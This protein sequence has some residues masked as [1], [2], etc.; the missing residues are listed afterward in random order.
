[1]A[2]RP[3]PVLKALEVNPLMKR[4]FW[5]LRR[6]STTIEPRYFV[7]LAE[8]ALAIVLIAAMLVTWFEAKAD[9]PTMELLGR[10]GR[11]ATW[12]FF[13]VLGQG[14]AGFVTTT[15]S[16]V[17]SWLLAL[18]GVAIVGTITGT[19]VALV[20][21]FLL[22][23]G[24][25]MGAAGYRDHIVVCGWNSTARDLIEELK[26]DEYRTKVVV[27]A[28]LEK[29]P[30][31][32]GVYFVRGDTTSAVDL[33][34][35]GIEDAAAALVFPSAPTNEADMQS[36]L[37]VMAIE[38]LAPTVRTVVEAV[39]PR[40]VEHF[41]RANADEVLVT[42]TLASRLLARSALY[43][44]LTGLVTD[45]V[46]GGAGSEL[47]RVEL[48][49][50]Y[51][52]LTIDEVSARLRAE[53]QATILAVSRGSTTFVNPKS[54]FRIEAGDDALVVALSLG[55]LAPL[56]ADRGMGG[57]G[58]ASAPAPAPGSAHAHAG[59]HGKRRAR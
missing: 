25:G 55:T 5:H 38:A 35:A 48:P 13:T 49:D 58:A 40:H 16:F 47:Y 11:T 22:K 44:G 12:S 39:N 1:M 23:E 21:D 33:G 14:S 29:N 51:L 2:G 6:T 36:I 8:G 3:L 56:K 37:T 52:G 20:I 27:L 30:A 19:L 59:T 46:S 17:V 9:E 34:R 10:F 50:A 53:H 26:G 31:G 18:F 15:A 28:D 42:S 24:Q 32:H 54:D 45:I 43:P 41:R 4:V 57:R 7:N